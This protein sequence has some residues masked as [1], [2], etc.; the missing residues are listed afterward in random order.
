MGSGSGPSGAPAV[1]VVPG[2]PNGCNSTPW[3]FG[4]SFSPMGAPGPRSCTLHISINGIDNPFQLV[5]NAVGSNL[6]SVTPQPNLAMGY[7]HV[8][9]STT[10]AI[11]VANEGTG[12]LMIG[13]VTFSTSTPAN[14]MLTSGMTGAHALAVNG[15]ENYNITCAPTTN[16]QTYT[17]SFTVNSDAS[18]MPMATVMVSCTGTDSQL[19]AAPTSF[20][21][22]RIGDP[23]VTLTVA[24][25]DANALG[26]TVTSYAF[27]ADT[28]PDLTIPMPS[29]AGITGA[30]SPSTTLHVMLRYTPTTP[31]NGY[32]GTLIVNYT[33]SGA[34]AHQYQATISG[35]ADQTAFAMTESAIDFGPVCIGENPV[36]HLQLYAAQPGAFTVSTSGITPPSMPFSVTS[37]PGLPFTAMGDHKNWLTLDVSVMPTMPVESS[38]MISIH[39][40]IPAIPGNQTDAEISLHVLGLP[41]DVAATPQKLEFPTT[42]VNDTSGGEVVQLTNCGMT[43]IQ[44][45]TATIATGDT[46]EFKVVLPTD[47][48]MM[49]QMHDV[50]PFTLVMNPHTPGPKS[51]TLVITYATGQQMVDLEGAADAGDTG[52]TKERETY[53]ACGTGRPVSAWPI[54]LALGWLVRRRRRA[55]AR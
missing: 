18:N 42:V 35:E 52:S 8:L 3:D 44:V 27:S 28:N 14:L 47:P 6:I 46:T 19:S 11:T 13:S 53:Y 10:D 49:L 17:G 23:P 33:D 1:G 55:A 39:T 7:V 40:D 38:S 37:T 51:A 31:A 29:G 24:V 12:T 21:A 26:D 41:M 20:P 4:V 25:S 54:A 5:G 32:L 48:A 15:S 16:N 43:A 9:S 50:E 30:V 22:R 2:T 36:H 34:T 45:Q